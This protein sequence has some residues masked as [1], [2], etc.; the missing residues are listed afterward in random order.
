MLCVT[1]R[2]RKTFI[3]WFYL[4]RELVTYLLHI[5][6]KVLNVKNVQE[7]F[8]LFIKADAFVFGFLHE[9]YGI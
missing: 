1:Q 9:S 5:R 8:L 6:Q 4:F 3:R 7:T 2:G